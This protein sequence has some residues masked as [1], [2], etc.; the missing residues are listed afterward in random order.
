MVGRKIALRGS[1]FPGREEPDRVCKF[2][3]K[4]LIMSKQRRTK[5]LETTALCTYL[6]SEVSARLKDAT[7]C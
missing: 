2:L 4:V 7:I 5:V 1:F 6:L 3:I